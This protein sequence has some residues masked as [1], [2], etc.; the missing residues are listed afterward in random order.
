MRIDYLQ[1][2][3]VVINQNIAEFYRA[4]IVQIMESAVGTE[5]IKSLDDPDNDIDDPDTEEPP[6]GT[7]DITTKS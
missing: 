2:I 5:A 4:R 3:E 1:N 7:W 6:G